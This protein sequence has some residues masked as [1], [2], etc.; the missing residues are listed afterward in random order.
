MGLSMSSLSSRTGSSG[1][2]MTRRVRRAAAGLLGCRIVWNLL[3]VLVV[4]GYIFMHLCK[5]MCVCVRP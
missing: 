5:Y 2:T 4:V 1:P 3:V